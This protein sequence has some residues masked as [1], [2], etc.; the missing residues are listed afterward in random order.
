MT[1]DAR[2][3]RRRAPAL[4]VGVTCSAD[5]MCLIVR[6]LKA[7]RKQGTAPP[8]SRTPYRPKVDQRLNHHVGTAHFRRRNSFLRKNS[9]MRCNRIRMVYDSILS[10]AFGVIK[11]I[12]PI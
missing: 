3:A 6:C 1:S 12:S 4:A 2:L 10:T 11:S 9:V 7:R 8:D 5:E